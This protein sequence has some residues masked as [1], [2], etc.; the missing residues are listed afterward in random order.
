VTITTQTTRVLDSTEHSIKYVEDRGLGACVRYSTWSRF[1]FTAFV[2]S[3]KI[4]LVLSIVYPFP[5]LLRIITY[6][7]DADAFYE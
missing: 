4:R 2:E 1:L 6:H 7:L 5:I 3:W